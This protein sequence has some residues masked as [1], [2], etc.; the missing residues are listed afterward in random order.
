[1]PPLRIVQ[2]VPRPGIIDVGWG[3]PDPELLPVQDLRAAADR[4][5]DRYGSDALG[6]GNAAG[7]GPF[8]E[9]VAERLGEIDGR[10]PDPRAR[11]SVRQ[12]LA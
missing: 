3:H 9:W 1:M 8:L 6:Y 4:V 11:W 10:A 12:T 2:F 7:P 5:L